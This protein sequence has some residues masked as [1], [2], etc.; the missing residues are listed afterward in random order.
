MK[1]ITRKITTEEF[2]DE[3]LVKRTIE[4]TIEEDDY[5]KNSFPLTFGDGIVPCKKDTITY[6]RSTA[7]SSAIE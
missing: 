4:E 6:Y 7:P 3:R 2:I 1:K 5:H